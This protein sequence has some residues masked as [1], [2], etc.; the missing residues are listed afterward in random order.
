MRTAPRHLARLGLIVALVA[1]VLASAA[2]GST[3]P[4]KRSTRN[5]VCPEVAFAPNSDNIAFNITAAGVSC[6]AGHTVASASAAERFRP[7][8]NRSY[9]AG[10]FA[11]RG[12]FVKPVGKWY[13]HYV[14][15]S[16]H[17]RVIF[18]RG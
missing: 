13:E 8:P 18:D 1:G 12:T 15:R 5:L 17:G 6:A 2:T 11:C 9:R 4:T 16:A 10:A 3:R 14:C 7:G